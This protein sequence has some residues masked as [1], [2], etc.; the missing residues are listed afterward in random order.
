MACA[1][2]ELLDHEGGGAGGKVSKGRA[3]D[4][5]GG[6]VEVLEDGRGPALVDRRGSRP[7]AIAQGDHRLPGGLLVGK[8][9]K[10]GERLVWRRDETQGRLGD[11]TEGPFGADEEVDGIESGAAQVAGGVLHRRQTICGQ[12]DL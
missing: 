8:E 11:D 2:G 6:G 4:V 10:A 3:Q 7:G 12:G 5:D 9:E 1:V